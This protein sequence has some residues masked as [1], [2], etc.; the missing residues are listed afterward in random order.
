MSTEIQWTEE[1]PS[2]HTRASVASRLGMS[3]TLYD[4]MRVAGQKRCTRHAAWHPVQRFGRDSSRR[5]GRAASCIEARASARPA[6]TPS[7]AERRTREASGLKWYRHCGEWVPGSGVRG[8]LC[9]EHCNTDYRRRYAL[10]PA[11]IRAQKYARKRRLDTIPP[12]WAEDHRQSF[13]GLCAYGC[14]R[15]GGTWDHIWPVARGG[16]SVPGNLVPACG[17]CNSSKGCQD[18]GPWVRR[19][20]A[21]HPDGW[22]DLVALAMLAGMEDEWIGS[23]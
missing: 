2:L 17:S 9:R 4:A 14:R 1:L 3:L 20:M 12:W 16:V 23:F 8:G 7:L 21:A 22:D 18:P 10:N 19:G 5:D 13:G 11:P 15:P 6:G